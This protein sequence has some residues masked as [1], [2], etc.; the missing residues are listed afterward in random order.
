MPPTMWHWSSAKS[1]DVGRDG[2]RHRDDAADVGE[3]ALDAGHPHVR[4]DQRLDR[5]VDVPVVLGAAGGRRPP[6]HRAAA[7]RRRRPVERLPHPAGGE[8][9]RGLERDRASDLPTILLVLMP[10]RTPVEWIGAA[11]ASS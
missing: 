8:S 5:L 9:G 1:G 4:L 11:L 2:H 6:P 10:M 3:E 7:R